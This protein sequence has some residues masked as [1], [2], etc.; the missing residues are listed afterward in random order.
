VTTS[1]DER[2][3]PPPTGD[4]HADLIRQAIDSATGE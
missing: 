4:E 1:P 3:Y 2:R